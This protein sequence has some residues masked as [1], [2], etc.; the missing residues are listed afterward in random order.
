MTKDEMLGAQPK[1]IIRM[2]KIRKASSECKD[3]LLAARVKIG[4][5]KELKDSQPRENSQSRCHYQ[6]ELEGPSKDL[7]RFVVSFIDLVKV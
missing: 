5:Q 3:S 7:N 4:E 2:A 1:S 6:R